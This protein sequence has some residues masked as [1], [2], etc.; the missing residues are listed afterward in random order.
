M[1]AV[2]GGAG[3]F[4]WG[5]PGSGAS[6]LASWLWDRYWALWMRRARA[7]ASRH[8]VWAAIEARRDPNEPLVLFDP[9][10][11]AEERLLHDQI[12]WAVNPPPWPLRARWWVDVH[13]PT[14]QWRNLV[15]AYQRARW[16]WSVEDTWNL[17]RYLSGVIAGS[18]EHLRVHGR[19]RSAGA[20][21]WD[22]TLQSIVAGF[23]DVEPDGV[24]DSETF[25]LFRKWFPELWD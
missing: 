16:G 9:S 18:V 13:G 6:L 4:W 7:R 3:A 8:P 11:G 23:S 10:V 2:R 22:R 24:P 15:R 1:T 14:R 25:D 17:D 5:P 19:H 21:Q 20:D 12:F